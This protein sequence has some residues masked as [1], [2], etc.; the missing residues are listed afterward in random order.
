MKERCE[1]KIEPRPWK[2]HVQIYF[3]VNSPLERLVSRFGMMIPPMGLT[4]FV[5]DVVN[6][7]SADK[8]IDLELSVSF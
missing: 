6:G 2:E 1:Y 5:K 7:L 8:L 3:L 4:V